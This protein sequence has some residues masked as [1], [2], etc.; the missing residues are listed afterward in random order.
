MDIFS[1]D[2]KWAAVCTALLDDQIVLT[3]FALFDPPIALTPTALLLPTPATA[4]VRPTAIS[5]GTSPSTQA[6]KP[7]P[8]PNDLAASPAKTGDPGRSSP[9]RSPVIPSFYSSPLPITSTASS[10]NENDPPSNPK[11]PSVSTFAGEPPFDRPSD[12][13]VPSVSAA[14]GDPLS[15]PRSNPKVSSASIGAGH[16]SAGSL[17]SVSSANDPPL[18]GSRQSPTDPKESVVPSPIQGGNGPQIQSQGLGAIIYNAFGKSGPKI[19]GHSTPSSSPRSIFTINAKTF[20]ANPTGFRINNVAITP[21]GTARTIDGTTISL[22]QSGILAIGSSTISLINPYSTPVLAVAGQT[23]TP[24]PSAYSIGA[25]IVLAGGPAVTVD[26]TA[27]SLDQSGALVVNSTT[28]SLHNLP[29]TPLTAEAFTVAGQIFTPNPSAFSTADTTISANGPATT[30]G[31]TIIILGHDGVLQIDSSTISLPSPPNTYSDK[32]YAVAGQTFTPNPSAFS[33]AGTIISA[34][35]PAVTVGGTIISLG[36]SGALALGSSTVVLPSTYIPDKAYTIAGQTFTPNLSAFPIASTVLSAGGPAVTI[37]GTAISLGQSGSL[38]IGSS[39]VRLGTPAY[40]P[41]NAYTV[42]GQT[43]TPNP[44]AFAVAG[45]TISA[46]GPA[47]TINGTLI[48]LEPSGT[49]PLSLPSQPPSDITIDGF[50]IKAHSSFVVVDGKTLSGAAP[51]V[52]VSGEVMSL[53]AGG[54]TLDIGTGHF[55]LPTRGARNGSSVNVQAFT[56]G[57]GRKGAKMSSFALVCIV[58]G[59]VVPLM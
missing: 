5:E 32:L 41:G 46:G 26:G 31:G 57:Q 14:A 27:I 53:E 6:A 52:T 58:C 38:A 22:G 24:D 55:A 39:T 11:A 12:P 2:S 20:A 36:Q 59:I 30:I 43:F 3:S 25:D 51:G 50:D 33:I 23:F 17:A 56:G 4:P 34:G 16:P 37:D 7:A 8:L 29:S 44:S 13:E 10:D 15:D 19:D 9:T 45:T 40:T 18:G 21:G 42:A 54:K 28:I 47:A 1:L 49:I 35:G 48:S